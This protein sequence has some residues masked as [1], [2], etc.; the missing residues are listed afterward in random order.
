MRKIG[1]DFEFDRKFLSDNHCF[2]KEMNDF[3]YQMFD[4]GRSALMFLLKKLNPKKVLLPAHN[5]V[6]VVDV[7]KNLNIDYDFYK[8]NDDLSIDI[9]S[10]KQTASDFDVIFLLHYFGKLHD[11]NILAEIKKFADENYAVI[12]ED[13]TH[14]YFT[15]KNTIGDYCIA[16]LR[17]WFAIPDCGL[18]YSLKYKI[19]NN[20]SLNQNLEFVNLRKNAMEIKNKRIFFNSERE[21]YLEYY[22]NAENYLDTISQAYK[23]SDFSKQ[24]LQS[25]NFDVLRANRK[26][27]FQ[28]LQD[29]IKNTKIT[30]IFEYKN[31]ETYIYF[32]VYAENRNDFRKYLF[33][34]QIFCGIHWTLYDEFVAQKFGETKISDNIL[35]LIIDQRFSEEEMKYVCEVINKY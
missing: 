35:S 30:K 28:Y 24:I 32:P 27:N 20:S 26:R 12:I 21:D 22:V 8:I 13:T 5:C 19:D 6:T 1:G 18:L 7:F 11:K 34:N 31:D 4:S 25:Y 33:E 15:C 14:S 23:I 9:E 29:N 3:S 2:E 17:K 16:S 10:L